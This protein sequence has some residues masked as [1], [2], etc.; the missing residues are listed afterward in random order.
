MRGS[1]L[2]RGAS[3]GTTDPR[4]GFYVRLPK[5]VYKIPMKPQL[6]CSIRRCGSRMAR[7]ETF[8]GSS[9]RRYAGLRYYPIRQG[10]QYAEVATPNRIVVR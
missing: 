9:E 1:E 2:A 5:K 4:V 7:G 8:A 10:R 3:R 6:R